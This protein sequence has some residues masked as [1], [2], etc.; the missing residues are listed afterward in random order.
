M[1]LL[2]AAL[3]SASFSGAHAA[4]INEFDYDQPG[5]DTAEF[6][7]VILESGEVDADF[8]VTLYNGSNTLA[9]ATHELTTFTCSTEGM[10]QR[11]VINLASNGLQNG[12]P[13]GLSLFNTNTMMI[14]EFLS[15]EGTFTAGDGDANGTMSTSVGVTEDNNMPNLSVQRAND[16]PMASFI[17]DTPTNA[18]MNLPVE[19][20]NFDID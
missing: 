7:E 15:Y 12:S 9:Y 14:V 13:D 2:L 20:L 3:V 1:R 10:I 5:T 17:T 16:D 19:L 6:I 4:Y 8:R 11:C 18:M